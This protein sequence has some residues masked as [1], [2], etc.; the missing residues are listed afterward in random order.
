MIFFLGFHRNLVM[1]KIQKRYNERGK[2]KTNT[3]KTKNDKNT[4]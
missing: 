4:I 3:E 2:K 1:E